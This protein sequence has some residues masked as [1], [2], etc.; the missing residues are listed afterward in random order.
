MKY[1][2]SM[3]LTASFIGCADRSDREPLKQFLHVV[4]RSL[5]HSYDDKL[6]GYAEDERRIRWLALFYRDQ[7]TAIDDYLRERPKLTDRGRKAVDDVRRTCAKELELYEALVAEKRFQLTD[8]EQRC[9]DDLR[10]EWQRQIDSIGRMID[11]K[12]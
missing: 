2:L 8:S 9:V 6:R 5:S 10:A 4:E 3:V 7:V 1:L 12:E 11:G